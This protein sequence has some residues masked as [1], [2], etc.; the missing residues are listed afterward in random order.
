M[1]GLRIRKPFKQEMRISIGIL[2]WN[3]ADSIAP[4][5]RSLFEQSLLQHPPKEVESIQIVCVPNGCTDRTADAARE[6][7]T[8]GNE[9]GRNPW[10]KCE[11]HE[12]ATAGKS[13]AWNEF[14]HGFSDPTADYVFFLDADVQFSSVDVLAKLLKSLSEERHAH[15][16][17]ATLVKNLAYKQRKSVFDRLSL[18]VSRLHHATVHGIAGGCYCGRGEV[19]R[20]I[21]LPP[22]LLT[23]DGFVRAMIVTD[24]FTHTDDV[25]RLRQVKEAVVVYEACT[26]MGDIFAHSRRVAVGSTFNAYVYGYLW[27]QASQQQDIGNL[28]REHNAENPG[29]ARELVRGRVQEAGWWVLPKGLV[30]NRLRQ[31]FSLPPQKAIL[32]LP[33]GAIASCFDFAVCISA[34]ALLK[35]NVISW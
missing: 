2:A 26:W 11:V 17:A 25:T 31:V 4:T 5:I 20:R 35:R 1:F 7:F 13:N 22:G 23:E 10:L 24:L 16:A 14:V 27:S 29:W 30:L 8:Q 12:I 6:A 33:I 21:W 15:V 34:N 3:E 18:A 32:S 19:L 28:I 9:R